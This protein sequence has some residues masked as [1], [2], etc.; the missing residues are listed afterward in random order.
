MSEA[1]TSPVIK[2][3]RLTG[4]PGQNQALREALSSLEAATRQEPGCVA[5]TLFQ[6]ITDADSFVLLEHFRDKQALEQH[7]QLPHTREFFAK[8]LIA[9][10][11]AVD[12]PSIG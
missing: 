2:I 6:A 5:F 12:V 11:N 7:M 4:K 8:Q 3:A 10:V 9:A 1:A